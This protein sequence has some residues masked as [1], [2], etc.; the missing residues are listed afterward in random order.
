MSKTKK[1]DLNTL[2][3]FEVF[4]RSSCN[5]VLFRYFLYRTRKE[6]QI[7][8][9]REMRDDCVYIPTTKL[10]LPTQV[11]WNCLK[12]KFMARTKTYLRSLIVDTNLVHIFS[13]PENFSTIFPYYCTQLLNKKVNKNKNITLHLYMRE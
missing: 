12:R 8:N 7:L 6:Q 11:P 9:T 5:Y 3:H 2:H 13:T 1:K 10:T 4:S